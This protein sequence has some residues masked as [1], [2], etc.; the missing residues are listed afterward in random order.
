MNEFQE[1]SWVDWKKG[2]DAKPQDDIVKKWND[3]YKSLF[4]DP[5][6]TF[7]G[8]YPSPCESRRLQPAS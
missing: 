8:P 4:S 7:V 6:G 5:D 3:I 2:N 1:K